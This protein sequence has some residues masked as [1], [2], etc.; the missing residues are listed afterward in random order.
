MN[1]IQNIQKVFMNTNGNDNDNT[2]EECVEDLQRLVTVCIHPCGT[3]KFNKDQINGYLHKLCGTNDS[4]LE[5]F[6][7]FIKVVAATVKDE[8][9]DEVP[10]QQ[11]P[12]HILTNVAELSKSEEIDDLSKVTISNFFRSD[13]FIQLVR[14]V[15]KENKVISQL[16][17]D[18]SNLQWISNVPNVLG[19]VKGIFKYHN[20]DGDVTS[21]M[22][23]LKKL[24]D[25]WY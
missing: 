19:T 8:A 11:I 5:V 7:N 13:G 23:V 21:C 1:A 12:R 24:S 25:A 15:A 20:S 4:C 22:D 2:F 17:S 3:E 6:H 9:N 14:G 16:K 10:V 18:L